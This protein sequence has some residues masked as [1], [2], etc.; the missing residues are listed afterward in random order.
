MLRHDG[1]AQLMR[2]PDGLAHSPHNHS[3]RNDN[4]APLNPLAR[5][6]QPSSAPL[7]IPSSS[8]GEEH[9]LHG[10]MPSDPWDLSSVQEVRGAQRV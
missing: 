7:P 2:S 1:C 10:D 3:L 5:P 4:M 6:Y 9:P 8:S